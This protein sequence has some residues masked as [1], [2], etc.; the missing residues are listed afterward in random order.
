MQTC[1]A[2]ELYFPL[3]FDFE[4]KSSLVD[5]LKETDLSKTENFIKADQKSITYKCKHVGEYGARSIYE[6]EY[7]YKKLAPAIC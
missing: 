6:C 3:Q 4:Q 7:I 1:K 2:D 5:Y